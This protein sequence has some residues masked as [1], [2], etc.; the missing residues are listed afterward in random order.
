MS[1]K[2][3]VIGIPQFYWHKK[4]W[5][6]SKKNPNFINMNISDFGY[7][8]SR[9]IDFLK[10][11]DD[12]T[13]DVKK[14]EYW[15]YSIKTRTDEGVYGKIDKY[16]K[17]YDRI[18][19]NGFVASGNKYNSSIIVTDDGCRLDGSHRV[20]ILLHLGILEVDVNILV[21]ERVFSKKESKKIRE[22]NLKYRK[23]TYG[24]E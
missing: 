11:L 6:F 8:C 14:S 18:K 15:E 24:M 16:K 12:P 9:H 7:D 19:F 1:V 20:A 13:K 4:A 23:E 2:T 3:P 21:Y 17:T 22:E 5:K 10:Y